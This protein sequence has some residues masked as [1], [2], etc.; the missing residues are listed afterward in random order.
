MTQQVPPG[1]PAEQPGYDPQYPGQP[2]VQ[3]GY[4]P[5]F[6]GQPGVQPGYGPQY[7]GQ[8]YP[9]Y[10]PPPM[11]GQFRPAK[12][13]AMGTAAVAALVTLLELVEA[14]LAWISGQRFQDAAN[15]G[16]PPS[17]TLTAYDVMALP[18]LAMLIVAGILTAL[19]LTQARKNAAALNPYARHA[20]SPI[21]AWLGWVV[22]IVS[23]WFPYQFV[24]DVRLATIDERHR[25]SNVVGWW[26]AMWLVYLITSQIG[27][28]IV[29][30]TDPNADLTAAL[31]P[32]ET[33]N[34][35]AAVVALALYLQV[36]RQ[37]TEDQ[38][39][40]AQGRPIAPPWAGG[41]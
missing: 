40:A 34:A 22:P 18:V 29:T 19:W 35:L 21:W 37:I 6:P 11:F 25:G 13:L 30:A 33:V 32:V 26:W 15:E 7:P 36:I 41:G 23:L 28:Q 8:S 31:G 39:T 9:Y 16:V 4:G 20:R 27:A 2:G 12:G 5:Y 38:E 24:R 14:V 3:P 1:Q 17:E 10:L